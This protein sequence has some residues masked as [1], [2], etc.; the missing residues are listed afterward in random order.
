MAKKRLPH[1]PSIGE[2][3]EEARLLLQYQQNRFQNIE[4]K[5]SS[6]LTLNSILFAITWI[7][8]GPKYFL[9]AQF[10]LLISIFFSVKVLWPRLGR[11]PHDREKLYDYA[12]LAKKDALDQFLLNYHK[13]I[14]NEDELNSAKGEDLK[15]VILFSALAWVIFALGWISTF[16]CAY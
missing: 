9:I 1:F 5:V 11:L 12:K 13:C 6:F 3:V 15:Y 2:T 4:A 7:F 10:C 14:K 8:N 16:V